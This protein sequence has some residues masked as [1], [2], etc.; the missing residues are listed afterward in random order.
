MIVD[1]ITSERDLEGLM[2]SEYPGKIF[3]NQI[4]ELGEGKN[5]TYSFIGLDYN[6]LTA[7]LMNFF[8]DEYEFKIFEHKTKR[9]IEDNRN[10]S[11]YHY[12]H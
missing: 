8:D 11:G 1:L 2:L 5:K 10:F 6:E 12:Y 3:R 4:A 7:F 9:L